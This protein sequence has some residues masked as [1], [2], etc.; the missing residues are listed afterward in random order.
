MSKNLWKKSFVETHRLQNAVFQENVGYWYTD[1]DKRQHSFVVHLFDVEDESI[2]Q[3]EMI[4]EVDETY[5]ECRISLQTWLD[6]NCISDVDIN[7]DEAERLRE[8]K[9]LW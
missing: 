8:E 1:D 5:M 2:E 4:Y 3:Q 9:G 6:G 7:R